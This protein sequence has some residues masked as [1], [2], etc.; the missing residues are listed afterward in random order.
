ME[1]VSYGDI[2]KF[3]VD[4][5]RVSWLIT[6]G[7][8]FRCHY[9]EFGQ[10]N[11]PLIPTS[12]M[13]YDIISKIKE[14]SEF[15]NISKVNIYSAEPTTIPDLDIYLSKLAQSVNEDTCIQIAT[16]LSAPISEYKKIIDSI[17]SYNKKLIIFPSFHKE[18]INVFDFFDKI[19]ILSN[20]YK[21]TDFHLGKAC[22]MIHSE[23]CI[24]LAHL[25]HN[26][27]GYEHHIFSMNLIREEEMEVKQI[28][29]E[30][31]FI[32][33]KDKIVRIYKN[34]D[35]KYND[36][37]FSRFT[38]NNFRKWICKCWGQ[39]ITIY[40]NGD[41][42]PCISI[43]NEGKMNLFVDDV[44]DFLKNTE[45][46]VCP[47]YQCVCDPDIPKYKILEYQKL[48]EWTKED[49]LKLEKL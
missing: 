34:G 18:F 11:E 32:E 42:T 23:K 8:N 3:G 7:C 24:N 38:S 2:D 36:R 35:Y 4:D 19:E 45:M 13:I 43:L 5:M 48:K 12:I 15:R 29:D 31:L 20:M 47:S 49:I 17:L 37:L 41:V 1:L 6:E 39:N 33:G 22:F 9:C 26:T 10:I 27:V 25:L 21:D 40:P 28:W 44:I 46:L 14:I 16:N 30:S